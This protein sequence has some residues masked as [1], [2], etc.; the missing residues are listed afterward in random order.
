MVL[1]YEVITV[2]EKNT[3]FSLVKAWGSGVGV[4]AER[5]KAKEAKKKMIINK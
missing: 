3:F 2:S 5:D 4:R 1:F